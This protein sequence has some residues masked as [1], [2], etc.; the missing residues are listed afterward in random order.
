MAEFLVKIADERGNLA[1]QVEHGYSETEVRD[2]FAQQGY[3]V[4][5]V[6]PRTVLSGGA[7]QFFVVKPAIPHNARHPSVLRDVFAKCYWEFREMHPV[8]VYPVCQP[9]RNA[10]LRNR[11]VL[12]Q[13]G[14]VLANEGTAKSQRAT[15]ANV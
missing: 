7:L 6:K 10:R 15:L 4:Y 2:R 1:Q 14:P 12:K 13:A 3:L 8:E 5:W 9:H 11:V